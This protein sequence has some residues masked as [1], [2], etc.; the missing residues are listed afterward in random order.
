MP[1]AVLYGPYKTIHNIYNGLDVYEDY[2]KVEGRENVYRGK[3][4]DTLLYWNSSPQ[5]LWAKLFEKYTGHDYEY[6]D[7]ETSGCFYIMLDGER[8]Y[9]HIEW[10]TL[11]DERV[12]NYHWNVRAH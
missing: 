8:W 1:S 4:T 11:D 5:D 10:I 3:T 12:K 7:D 6:S 9:M 2:V